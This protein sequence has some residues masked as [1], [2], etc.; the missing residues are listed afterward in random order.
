MKLKF[1]TLRKIV[2]AAYWCGIEGTPVSVMITAPP[3][4]GKTW[5]TASLQKIDFVQYIGK[6]ISPNE[7]RYVIARYADRTRLLIN[8]DLS[9][10]SRWN[11]KE[12]FSTF[13][14]IS[15]GEIRFTQYKSTVC[16]QMKCSLVLCCTSAYFNDNYEAMEAG[17]LL[18]RLLLINVGL[19]QETR[20][21]YQHAVLSCPIGQ[22]RTPTREPEFLTASAC[23]VA[24]EKNNLLGIKN[25]DPRLLSN[26]RHISQFLTLDETKE[27]IAVA[28]ADDRE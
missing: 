9:L 11:A 10:C 15:D 25:I 20:A 16:A 8:D 1:L 26:L 12:Y 7:H 4:S 23:D 17:G 6:P 5:S 28:H 13:N 19:S 24:L 3:G 2:D 27:L 14:M 21:Y 18:D 22:S